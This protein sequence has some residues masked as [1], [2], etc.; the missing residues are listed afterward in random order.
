MIF[1]VLTNASYGRLTTV[2]AIMLITFLPIP[3]VERVFRWRR[4]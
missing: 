2:E 1:E 3:W 4:T